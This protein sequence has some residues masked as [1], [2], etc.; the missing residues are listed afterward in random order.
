MA[1][2]NRSMAPNIAFVGRNKNRFEPLRQINNGDMTI[3]LPAD[4]SKPF[5]H[6]DGKKICKLY[7]HHYKPVIPK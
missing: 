6:P 5:F 3:K 7:P 2:K 4:Q 1:K